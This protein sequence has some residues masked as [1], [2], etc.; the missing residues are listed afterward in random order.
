ML[1]LFT[2]YGLQRVETEVISAGDIAC[3]TGCGDLNV[4]DTICDPEQ[5]D[6]M[7]SLNVD[8]PTISMNFGANQSPFS[9]KEGKWV[10]STK[11][12]ERLIQEAKTNVALRVEVSD[13]Q[14]VM[15]VSGRG[16]LHLGILIEQMRREGFEL[17]IS[18]P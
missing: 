15:K 16:E 12:K 1:K 3:V 10:T 2:H 14:E 9:G 11:I 7:P 6:A 8:E 5:V 4:S 18:R 17:S 13:D